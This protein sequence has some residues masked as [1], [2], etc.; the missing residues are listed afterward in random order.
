MY[1]QPTVGEHGKDSAYVAPNA[2]DEA[3]GLTVAVKHE[4]TEVVL[5]QLH[6][7]ARRR[8][9][10]N[11][12]LQQACILSAALMVTVFVTVWIKKG[13]LPADLVA[14]FGSLTGFTGCAYGATAKYRQAAKAAAQLDDAR[15]VGPLVD[16]LILG[17]REL[18][19]VAVSALIRLLPRLKASDSALLSQDQRKS[20]CRI[21]QKACCAAPTALCD[22]EID[23]AVAALKAFEQV[24]DVSVLTCVENAARYPAYGA[25]QQVTD[26]AE[27]CL[28]FL[29]ER[30]ERDRA[31]R[32]LLRA[33]DEPSMPADI[34]LRPASETGET[35]SR[36]LLR[37]NP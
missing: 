9:R 18:R 6:D 26:A 10:R 31:G 8:R 32:S 20:L 21:V 23:L 34:L 14:L 35:N 17:D 19:A 3:C 37:P 25:A 16:S 30:I 24:G 13:E 4:E 11:R 7:E 27:T 33:S 36:E 22:R 28:P 5:Q 29:K 12:Y 2:A 15:A 1:R